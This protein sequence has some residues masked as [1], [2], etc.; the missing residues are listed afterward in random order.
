MKVEDN[1]P[2][3]WT[4]RGLVP[5]RKIVSVFRGGENRP[6]SRGPSPSPGRCRAP[7]SFLSLL[8]LPR[9]TCPGQ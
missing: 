2:I 1:E 3:D 5:M 7:K 9:A 4:R 6:A 8:R